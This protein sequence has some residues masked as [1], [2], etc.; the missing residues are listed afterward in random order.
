MKPVIITPLAQ[1]DMVSIREYYGH[2][3]TDFGP[4]LIAKFFEQFHI[5]SNFPLAG[6]KRS[7]LRKGLLQRVVRPYLIFYF[8]YGDRIEIVRVVDD[9][10]QITRKLHLGPQM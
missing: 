4:K 9:R 2:S 10:R 5:I 1:S 7:R 6:A 8:I 3:S